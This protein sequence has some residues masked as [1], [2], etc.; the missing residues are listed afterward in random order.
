RRARS[1]PSLA[2]PPDACR[3]G[4]TAEVGSSPHRRQARG[5]GPSRAAATWLLARAPARIRGWRELQLDRRIDREHDLVA[6]AE[7]A[8]VP[9]PRDADDAEADADGTRDLA[10]G[11]AEEVPAEE[12]AERWIAA[13]HVR[14]PAEVGRLVGFIELAMSGRA[15]GEDRERR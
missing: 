12:A 8:R 13:F 10:G 7:D 14:G 2:G 1:S 3:S 4:T 5:K 15:Q 9:R 6:F 11:N